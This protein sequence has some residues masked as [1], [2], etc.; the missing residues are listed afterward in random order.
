MLNVALFFMWKWIFWDQQTFFPP[1][2][3]R[4]PDQSPSVLS[5]ETPT[6]LGIETADLLRS[7]WG[8]GQPE[9]IVGSSAPSSIKRLS[10]EAKPAREPAPSGFANTPWKSE[11]DAED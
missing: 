3:S 5:A 10:R 8:R 1:F 9:G 11:F 7:D 6:V 2:D 4:V